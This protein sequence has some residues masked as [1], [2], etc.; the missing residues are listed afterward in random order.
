MRSCPCKDSPTK[1]LRVSLVLTALR[2]Y[3]SSV[4]IQLYNTSSSFTGASSRHRVSRSPWVLIFVDSSLHTSF[5]VGQAFLRCINT[6]LIGS[7]PLITH[8][9]SYLP[10]LLCTCYGVRGKHQLV[11]SGSI[12]HDPYSASCLTV[13]QLQKTSRQSRSNITPVSV[14]GK[15]GGKALVL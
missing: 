11:G 9:I 12:S 3:F 13:F 2:S 5:D 8:S 10:I 4:T 14:A 1:Q 15:D 7:I 6:L